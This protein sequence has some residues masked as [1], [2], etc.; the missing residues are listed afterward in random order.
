MILHW[1]RFLSIFRPPRY[2][3]VWC[4][5]QLRLFSHATSRQLECHADPWPSPPHDDGTRRHGSPRHAVH[6]VRSEPALTR[7]YGLH[8]QPYTGHPRWI[9]EQSVHKTIPVHL[10]KSPHCKS[11][12]G[13]TIINTASRHALRW[14]HVRH[15]GVITDHI[16]YVHCTAYTI[17]THPRHQQPKQRR[18]PQ[19]LQV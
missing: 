2:G 5:P 8:G 1:L 13:V 3:H 16:F 11:Y 9:I 18:K 15:F 19:R 4:Q 10:R 14:H 7:R 12:S 17:N 6:P